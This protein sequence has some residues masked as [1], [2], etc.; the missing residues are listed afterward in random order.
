MAKKTKQDAPTAHELHERETASQPGKPTI[1]PTTHS[2]NVGQREDREE[3]PEVHPDDH[4][5]EGA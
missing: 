3:P 5:D 1:S 4:D 2:E